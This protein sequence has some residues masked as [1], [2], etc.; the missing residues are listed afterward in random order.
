MTSTDLP[1][2]TSVCAIGAPPAPLPMMTTSNNCWVTG[3]DPPDERHAVLRAPGRRSAAILRVAAERR[4]EAAAPVE[5]RRS[6]DLIGQPTGDRIDQVV[7]QVCPAR[8]PG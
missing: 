6:R 3:I 7:R 4:F 8:G 2:L 1:A 5:V